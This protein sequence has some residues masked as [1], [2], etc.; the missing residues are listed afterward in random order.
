MF[1]ELSEAGISLRSALDRYYNVCSTT[2]S[3]CRKH[4][5]NAAASE[6]LSSELSLFGT[7]IE[8][9]EKSEALIAR[10][11]NSSR[12]LAPIN[13]LPPEILTH[14]INLAASPEHEVGGG[15][16]RLSSRGG[17]LTHRQPA[18]LS[19]V[20]A[21]WRHTVL[22]YPAFWSHIHLIHANCVGQSRIAHAKAWGQRS[23]PIPLD[24]HILADG[25]CEDPDEETALTDFLASAASRQLASLS[26][27]LRHVDQAR[28]VALLNKYILN[29]APGTLK[30]LVI[31]KTGTSFYGRFLKPADHKQRHNSLLINLPHARLEG[32]WKSVSVL[33]LR[34]IYLNWG[35][36]VYHGLV[37]LCLS[38]DHKNQVDFPIIQ[39]SQLVVILAASPRLTVIRLDVVIEANTFTGEAATQARLDHLQILD[40]NFTAMSKVES[41]LRVVLPLIHPGSQPLE[42]LFPRSFKPDALFHNRDL[43]QEFISRCTIAQLALS[44]QDPGLEWLLPS[45]PHLQ[46]LVIKSDFRQLLAGSESGSSASFGAV[47]NLYILDSTIPLDNFYPWLSQYPALRKLIFWKCQFLLGSNFVGNFEIDQELEQW[48]VLPFCPEI[49]LISDGPSP[50]LG[51]KTSP[52]DHC[53]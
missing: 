2:E 38:I 43:V 30:K 33:R 15:R 1:E 24:I 25:S 3:Y 11:R 51:W 35:S 39:E 41:S 18:L 40:L 32:L 22:Q 9:L 14:I 10:S 7:F 50:I 4:D 52:Y 53:Y 8:I 21:Q 49:K 13:S 5:L 6:R 42:L 27:T 47:Q 20:C 26:F 34:G 45:V 12:H 19:L 28:E 31:E 23:H 36:Q 16:N 37:E 29:W 44:I 17:I 46:T 48:G